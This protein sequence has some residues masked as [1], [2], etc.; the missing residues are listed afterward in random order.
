VFWR[1]TTRVGTVAVGG[2][3]S[4][5][6]QSTQKRSTLR[7]ETKKSGREVLSYVKCVSLHTV[8]S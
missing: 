7:I 4:S 2:L 6:R 1:G 8:E 3:L 5:A